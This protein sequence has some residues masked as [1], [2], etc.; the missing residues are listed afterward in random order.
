MAYG[1]WHGKCFSCKAFTKNISFSY[2]QGVGRADYVEKNRTYTKR[3]TNRIVEEVLDSNIQSVAKRNGLSEE[4]IQTILKD[5]AL[6]FLKDKPKPFRRLGIDEISLVKGQGN[7]C[8]VLVDIDT[9]KLL[10]IVESRCIESLR[11]VLQSWGDEILSQIEEV[12]MDLWK[13]YKSLVQELMPNA[14]IVPDRFHI[15][16]QVTDELDAQRKV[17]KKEA[18]S[19]KDRAEKERRLSAIKKSKY[20]LL[21]NK[22]D[23]NPQQEQKLIEVKKVLPKLANMHRLKEEFREIFET[24]PNSGTGLLKLL[25]WLKDAAR[26]FPKSSQT[27]VRWFGDI[28]NYFEHRTTNG[29]VE[30]INNKL[31]LIKRAAYGFRN[32]ENFKLRSLLNWHFNI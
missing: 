17:E 10:A 16:K 32:F 25:D 29:V 6:Q 28:I 1:S 8:A 27:I 13:P 9:G 21:K 14:E 4:E 30:G 26:D 15:M 31:K 7:Y 5:A 3:L 19:L 20:A 12:S 22:K 18:E 24:S 11:K 2:H 23:L